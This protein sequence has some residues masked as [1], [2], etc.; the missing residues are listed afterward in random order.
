MAK[1]IRIT[2]RQVQTSILPKVQR[3]AV[4]AKTAAMLGQWQFSR[5]QH[6]GPCRHGIR[7]ALCINGVRWAVADAEAAGI[8]GAALR[9]I[10]AAVR[11]TWEQG[12][13]E[14][15]T[16]REQCSRCQSELTDT[17]M[18]RGDRFCGTVCAKAALA[19][20]DF[21][22]RARDHE[23]GRRAGYILT[24]ALNPPRPCAHCG[25]TYQPLKADGEFCSLACS[26]L[27]RKH[28]NRECRVCGTSF[29]P[30]NPSVFHCSAECGAKSRRRQNR[31]CAS[32]GNLFYP[33]STASKY[34]SDH[35]RSS[36]PPRGAQLCACCGEAFFP[37][38]G[39]ATVCS[40]QCKE[41]IRSA[42]KAE[43]S[44]NS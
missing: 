5:Y 15:T 26:G 14:Y 22:G 43:R 12:Q 35:C 37:R 28:K 31:P 4:I 30:A 41:K 9:Q 39:R 7:Q 8:V 36:G 32:C 40:L 13:R 34:C 27:S 18:M 19:E 21:E 11:P 23:L 17:Q 44:K 2:K 38:S 29:H 1:S 42:R 25:Q 6:E 20:R 24:R 16:P 10:G 3:E 33:T